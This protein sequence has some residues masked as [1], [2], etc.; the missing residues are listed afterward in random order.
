M[1]TIVNTFI[2]RELNFL[3]AA[4]IKDL[5]PREAQRQRGRL[6]VEILFS[7]DPTAVF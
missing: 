7:H 3:T 6:I 2:A 5:Q 4:P 1:T